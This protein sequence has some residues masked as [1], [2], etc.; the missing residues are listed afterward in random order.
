MTMERGEGSQGLSCRPFFAR[1]LDTPAVSAA[2]M[3]PQEC[4]QPRPQRVPLSP[5]LPSVCLRSE[6]VIKEVHNKSQGVTPCSSS[7]WD[8]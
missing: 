5:F 1:S 7:H 2:G 8:C 4:E 6:T 3:C